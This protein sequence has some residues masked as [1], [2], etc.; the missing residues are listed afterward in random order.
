MYPDQPCGASGPASDPCPNCEHLR[1]KKPNTTDACLE[2]RR[3]DGKHSWKFDGDDP[4]VVCVFCKEARDALTGRPVAAPVVEPEQSTRNTSDDKTT[5]IPACRHTLERGCTECA[6][7]RERARI[8]RIIEALP[9]RTINTGEKCEHGLFGY[10]DC[11][12]CYRT[13][14]LT[15]IRGGDDA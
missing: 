9:D 13:A 10:E 12:D 1:D 2:S 7:L 8:E 11:I 15:A 14:L 4:Y 6:E 3:A 5:N